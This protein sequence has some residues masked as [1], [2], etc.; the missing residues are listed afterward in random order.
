[1]RKFACLVVNIITPNNY[2]SLFSWLGL[3]LVLS[4]TSS[5]EVQ[6]LVFFCCGISVMLFDTPGNSRCHNTLFLSSP[7]L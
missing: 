6:L 7:H 2:E 3:D 5:F 4:V 1:M